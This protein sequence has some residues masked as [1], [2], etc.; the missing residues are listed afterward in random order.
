M[1]AKYAELA[2]A[3]V[4]AQLGFENVMA[5]TGRIRDSVRIGELEQRT[6]PVSFLGLQVHSERLIQAGRYDKARQALADADRISPPPS[7]GTDIRRLLLAISI[8]EHKGIKTALKN[9]IQA[10]Q[11]AAPVTEAILDA[12]DEDPTEILRLLRDI[13][14]NEEALTGEARVVIA[15]IAAHHNDPELALRVFNK[16]LEVNVQRTNRLWYPFFSDMRKLPGFK[17]LA[18]RLGFVEY[19]RTYGWADTCR[20]LGDDDFECA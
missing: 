14:D 17:A 13:F 4:P 16:E 5:R 19:W 3:D 6:N 12:F 18:E 11:R 8:G 10:D 2:P 20:P 1:Y 15:S 9:Y 7:Q